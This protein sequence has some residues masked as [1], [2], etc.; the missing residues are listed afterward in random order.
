MSNVTSCFLYTLLSLTESPWLYGSTKC[1]AVYRKHGIHLY[2]KTGQTV[3]NLLVKPKDPLETLE[4]C[5]V[6]YESKCDVCEGVY[7][8]ESGRSLR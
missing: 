5:G 2:S 1:P 3:R 6:V 4:Q 8:G 7:V